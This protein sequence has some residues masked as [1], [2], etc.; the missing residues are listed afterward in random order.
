M[1]IVYMANENELE[2][3]KK[4]INLSSDMLS[5]KQR[6]SSYLGYPKE[7]LTVEQML[8]RLEELGMVRNHSR[9]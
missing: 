6:L 4:Y 9:G 5:V 3:W 8:D 1:Y 2:V 7:D